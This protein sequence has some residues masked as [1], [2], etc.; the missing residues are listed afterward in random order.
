MDD[1]DLRLQCLRIANEAVFDYE[2]PSQIVAAAAQFAEFVVAGKHSGMTMVEAIMLTPS[3]QPGRR[4][5]G[6]S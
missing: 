4:T 6:D 2:S 3:F 5:R 1:K